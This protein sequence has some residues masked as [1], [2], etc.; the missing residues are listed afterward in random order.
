VCAQDVSTSAYEDDDTFQ[1][2]ILDTTNMFR[3]QHNASAL[4][5][6]DTLQD[7]AEEWVEG[8]EFE[9]SVCLHFPYLSN[10]YARCVLI[11]V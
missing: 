3:A 4:G 7:A 1:K 11:D 6:N 8:C 2:Q 9:H 10:G 5:W